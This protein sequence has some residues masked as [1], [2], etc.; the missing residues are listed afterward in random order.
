MMLMTLIFSVVAVKSRTS[1]FPYSANERVCR[2]WEWAEPG[3]EP[4]LASGNLPYHGRHAL[5]TNG[6]WPGGRKLSGFLVSVSSNPLFHEFELFWEFIF[7]GRFAEFSN[8]RKL[9][10]PQLLIGDWLL[11]SHLVVRKIVLCIVCFA[12]ELLTLLLLVV[13]V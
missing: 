10:V 13:V 2:S 8:T 9:G 4:K 6:G 5:F 7:L 12:Y 1:G 11:I 3:S